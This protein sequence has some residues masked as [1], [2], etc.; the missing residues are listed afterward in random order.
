M[1]EFTVR[2]DDPSSAD[3]QALIA[4]HASFTRRHSPLEDVHALAVLELLGDHVSFFSIREGDE[5]IAVGA[6]K[7]LDNSMS[8]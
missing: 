8:S 3:V 7:Q 6:L 1:R 2:V 4:E 5:L